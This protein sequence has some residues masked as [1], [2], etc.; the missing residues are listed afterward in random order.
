MTILCSFG[1]FSFSQD[2]TKVQPT[3]KERL[4][5]FKIGAQIRP[6]FEYRHGFKR[7]L[8]DT[9]KA[10]AFVEQRTRLWFDVMHPKFHIHINV[11][12]IR[13]W[14]AT[15]QIYKTD[16]SL[17]NVYEAYGEV[18]LTNRWAL[19]IG[20]QSMPYDNERFMGGLDWA[21]QGR[22]HDGVLV[23]YKDTTKKFYVDLGG[24]FNSNGYEPTF[25]SHTTYQLKNNKFMLFAWFRK[26]WKSVGFSTMIHNDGR[27]VDSSGRIGNRQTLA[28]IPYFKI[29]KKMQIDAEFYFQLGKNGVNQD[30]NAFFASLSFTYKTKITP[31]T[32]GS[33]LASGSDPNLSTTKDNAWNPV[34]GT[35]HKFYGH[36]DYFYVGNIHGQYGRVGGLSDT[37]VKTKFKLDK[38]GNH[39]FVLHGHLFFS[40]TRIFDLTNP[41]VTASPFLGGEVDLSY[42]LKIWKGIYFDMGYSQ[43]FYSNSVKQLKNMPHATTKLAFWA[44]ASINFKMDFF[45]I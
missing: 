35:N 30:V 2:S 43:M 15:D 13:M 12:D 39:Q 44:W 42:H 6:R 26:E 21:Q 9:V 27:E 19:K 23:T 32:I 11:Q 14:G 38:K 22:S 20:R 8:I 29:G 36:M 3:K 28:V 1:L 7:P 10:G 5:K 34:Y 16:R 40:P 18:F 25:L 37:Y 45:K 33:D 24:S 41:S 4:T 17:F 31:I